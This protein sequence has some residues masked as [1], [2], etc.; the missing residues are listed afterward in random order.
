MSREATFWDELRTGILQAYPGS[1]LV[2]IENRV[3]AG[4]PDVNGCIEGVDFWAELK[5]IESAPKRKGIIRIP[6]YTQEQRL[7]I[8]KRGRAGGRVGLALKVGRPLRYFYFH[9]QAC[10]TMVGKVNLEELIN[11]AVMY[12]EGP[13]PVQ[14]MVGAMLLQARQV[15]LG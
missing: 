7:W 3:G 15:E 6:H 4:M 5:A 2:R 8:R 11:C 1:H 14:S 13:L 12:S 10:F 9:W